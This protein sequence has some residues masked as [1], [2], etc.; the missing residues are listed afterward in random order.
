MN[1]KGGKKGEA[2][3]YI[4]E[5]LVVGQVVDLWATRGGRGGDAR[6]LPLSDRERRGQS[7]GDD[8]ISEGGERERDC[9]VGSGVG[10]TSQSRERNRERARWKREGDEK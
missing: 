6:P 5:R 4:E 10:A 7:R 9:E 2:A 1:E 8:C 3:A